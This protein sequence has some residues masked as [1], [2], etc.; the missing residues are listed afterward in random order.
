MYD[1]ML[2]FQG[3]VLNQC[4]GVLKSHGNNFKER[5]RIYNAKKNKRMKREQQGSIMDIDWMG[6]GEE[7]RMN[8][9]QNDGDVKQ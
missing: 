8:E 7:K 4:M 9:E 6:N 3:A 2:V 1:M 5:K